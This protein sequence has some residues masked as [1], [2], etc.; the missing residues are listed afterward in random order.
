MKDRSGA[1]LL[2]LAKSIY[3][4]RQVNDYNTLTIVNAS[5][6]KCVNFSEL[7]SGVVP[8]VRFFLMRLK[9]YKWKYVVYYTTVRPR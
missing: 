1:P 8:L 7:V 5:H 9:L 2:G 4:I 3:Y 6:N